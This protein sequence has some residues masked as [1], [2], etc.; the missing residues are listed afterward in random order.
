MKVYLLDV[1]G[2][3]P[4]YFTDEKSLISYLNTDDK[5][6]EPINRYQITVVEAQV[7]SSTDGLTY[8]KNFEKITRETNLRESKLNA[9]LG[10][11]YAIAVDKLLSYIKDNAKDNLY[12]QEFLKAAE[13]VSV[14]KKEFSKFITNYSDY[15]V[16]Q[17]SDKVEYYKLLFAV[18]NFRKI[19]DR[20]TV[21]VYDTVGRIRSYGSRMTSESNKKNFLLAKAK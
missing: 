21:P 4:R 11:E 18:H 8:V 3:G 12:R 10:D 16:Y 20:Y 5:R 6:G 17:I 9:V 19:N 2:R 14:E 13:L 7:E 1:Y 15:V